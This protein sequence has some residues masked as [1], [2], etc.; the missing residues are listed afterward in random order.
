LNGAMDEVKVATLND[1]MV[2]FNSV[3]EQYPA[4]LHG[5][6]PTKVK[7]RR[8]LYFFAIVYYSIFLFEVNPEP[9]RKL[10]RQS[11]RFKWL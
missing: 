10:H 7:H 3:T 6:G 4:F 9:D 11:V 8:C 1:N 5:N 2:I